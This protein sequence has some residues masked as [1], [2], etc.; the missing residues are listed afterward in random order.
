[1][2]AHVTWCFSAGQFMWKKNSLSLKIYPSYLCPPA[3]RHAEDHPGGAETHPVLRLPR[4]PD[5]EGH[6]EHHHQWGREPEG[7][8]RELS[9]RVWGRWATVPELISHTGTFKSVCVCDRHTVRGCCAVREKVIHDVRKNLRCTANRVAAHL[10][11]YWFGASG[12]QF[13]KATWMKYAWPRSAKLAIQDLWTA[14]E[15]ILRLFF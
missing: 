12:D 2:S 9:D 10:L 5:H 7:K 11:I 3:V 4:S 6:W 15:G 14:A 8:L 1:M 13:R